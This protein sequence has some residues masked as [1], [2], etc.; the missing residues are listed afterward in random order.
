LLINELKSDI[1]FLPATCLVLVTLA[2]WP[3]TSIA[4]GSSQL[5]CNEIAILGAVKS[6]GR[7]EVA[8]RL[9]LVEALTKVGG[10]S[11]RAGKLVKVIRFCQCSPCVEGEVRS[12]SITEYDLSAAL[13]GRE[14]ANPFVEAG[15]RIIVP[16]TEV[17]FVIGNG[18]SK[19][20][21]YR[22]GVTLTQAIAPVGGAARYSDLVRVRIHRNSAAD[23]R[24]KPFI[25]SLKAVLDNQSE[26]PVLEPR[27]IIEISDEAGNFRPRSTSPI[28][29]DSPLIYP[30]GEPPL[31][32]RRS[33]NC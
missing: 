29:R 15:D 12:T 2:V 19:S 18:F 9:R 4:Q 7:F 23:S 14:A 24:P 3:E 30:S 26:D 20:L 22:E 8:A 10:P 5:S 33:S 6:P 16:E 13:A 28:F 17:I 32:Q 27:D 25:F 31:V 1:R 21:V 11:E